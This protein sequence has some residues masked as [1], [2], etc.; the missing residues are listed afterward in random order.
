[1]KQGIQ[2]GAN[3]SI[4]LANIKIDALLRVIKSNIKVAALRFIKFIMHVSFLQF[5]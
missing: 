4:P 3:P 2:I 1:M 5:F